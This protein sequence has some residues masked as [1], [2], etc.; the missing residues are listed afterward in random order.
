M[1]CVAC[2]AAYSSEL[3]LGDRL[4]PD[5]S[6]RTAAK[7]TVS[8]LRSC[9]NPRRKCASASDCCQIGYIRRATG[10]LLSLKPTGG[11][12][13]GGRW[14]YGGMLPDSAAI[15]SLSSGQNNRKVRRPEA[16]CA[17]LG[18]RECGA[19]DS[20]VDPCRSADRGRS[21]SRDSQK[22]F[23]DFGIE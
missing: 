11:T 15:L 6:G 22:I 12:H 14:Q 21:K 19:T 2:A 17:L 3:P 1:I 18:H 16:L 13:L 20:M 7:M 23:A 9:A 10:L 8:R 5:E 4:M